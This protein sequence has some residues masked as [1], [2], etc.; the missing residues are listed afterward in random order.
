MKEE[1]KHLAQ[2]Q[3]EMLH[4]I[5][6]LLTRSRVQPWPITVAGRKCSLIG[7][8]WVKVTSLKLGWGQPWGTG[9][10]CGDCLNHLLFPSLAREGFLTWGYKDGQH[11][12]HDLWHWT[13]ETV[14]SHMQSQSQEGGHSMARRAMWELHS[15]IA[16][17]RRVNPGFHGKMWWACLNNFAGQKPGPWDKQ[18]LCLVPV[19]QGGY[20]LGGL[21]TTAEQ[22]GKWEARPSEALLVSPD[23]HTMHTTES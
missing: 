18:K 23:V 17:A 15:G 10:E 8:V 13:D 22:R 16:W 14:I 21:C 6:L 20:C 4:W 9:Y 12:P 1:E 11:R 7:Q 2:Q 19:W 3:E 5:S